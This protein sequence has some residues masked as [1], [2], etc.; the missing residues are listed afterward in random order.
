AIY[1]KLQVDAVIAQTVFET[2]AADMTRAVFVQPTT[3]LFQPASIPT[4]TLEQAMEGMATDVFLTPETG[5]YAIEQMARY[6]EIV[7]ESGTATIEP[8]K[9]HNFRQQTDL[10]I[11]LAPPPEGV[12]AEY[13]LLFN[14]GSTPTGLSGFDKV[15]W[16]GDGIP[17]PESNKSYYIGIFAFGKGY[18]GGYLETDLIPQ[19][20]AFIMT[21]GL[22]DDGAGT[23][24]LE[25]PSQTGA[26]ACTVYWGDGTASDHTTGTLSHTYEDW[27]TYRVFIVGQYSG[28]KMDD[29]AASKRRLY[30]IEHLG[31]VSFTSF[32]AAF[33]G[34]VNL[35]GEAP[36][37]WNLY[38]SLDGTECFH[39]CTGLDNYDDIPAEWK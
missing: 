28:V 31:D 37:L 11:T 13:I 39:G 12:G 29:I 34:C 21:W 7:H 33:K 5:K 23:K 15:T 38:P 9:V 36:P 6:P 14:S 35:T 26:F 4:A 25:I 19:A 16:G 20:D 32:N 8:F 18:M 10:N 27:G 17:E 2:G 1:T 22:V 3:N 30:S 24:I